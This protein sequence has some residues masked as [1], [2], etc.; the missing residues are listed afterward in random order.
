MEEP[1]V[2][3]LPPRPTQADDSPAQSS[4]FSTSQLR[5]AAGAWLCLTLL[6][7]LVIIFEFWNS[8]KST[9]T[10]NELSGLA[11]RFDKFQTD[12]DEFLSRA[13]DPA[14]LKQLQ[15]QHDATMQKIDGIPKRDERQQQTQERGVCPNFKSEFDK[16]MEDVPKEL[17][18]LMAAQ[19]AALKTAETPVPKTNDP[20]P[21]KVDSVIALTAEI[22]GYTEAVKAATKTP[23]DLESRLQNLEKKHSEICRC[24]GIYDGSTSADGSS[25]DLLTF[26]D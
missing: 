4:A 12:N 14:T 18:T 10:Q 17:A 25:S 16:K 11:Q 26:K 9:K 22:K 19:I 20:D 5:Y 2:Q 21:P 1:P 6:L 15:T 23:S 7:L 24:Q 3:K 13:P 8:S